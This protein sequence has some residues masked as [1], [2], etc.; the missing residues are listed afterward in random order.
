[1]VGTVRIKDQYRE[2]R[3]F[4]QRALVAGAV[5]GAMVL[6]LLGRLV[7]LQ[8]IHHE[9]YLLRAEG[10]RA[11]IEPIPA[12][13][14]LILDRNGLVLAENQATY[15]LELV[16]EQ[17][18]DLDQTLQGLA[19]IG[20]IAAED[21]E[22]V[23]RDVRAR[24]AFEA[25]P[26]QRRLTEE[27]IAAFAAH[28]HQFPGVD[29]RWR[30][31]RYYP[32]GSLAVHALGY[33]GTISEADLAKIDETAYR[34]TTVIGKRGVEAARE[35]DLHGVNG[36]REILVNAQ[37]RSVQEQGGLNLTLR[38][39]PPRAGSD[40]ILSLD[41]PTQQ[42]A[43]AAFAGRRGAAI[44]L[45][46]HNGDV[47]AFVSLPGFDPSL[48]G[49]GITAKEYRALE[50]DIDRPLFNRA[51][52]GT[53][54]PGS[55][56]KPVLGM[57][58][59]AYG[60]VTPDERRY[61]PGV[62]IVP[63]SSR[64]ARE[65][66][67][68][69]HGAVDLRTS[70]S[71]SCDVYYYSLAVE[72]GVDRIHEFLS[73]FGFG[74]RTGIDIAG[75]VSG[76]LPSREWKKQRYAG[77]DPSEGNWYPGDSVNFGI[78]QGY[79]TVTPMQLAQV[80]AVLAAKG[81]VFQPRLVTGIRDPVSGETRAVEPVELPHVKGGTPAQWDV[82]MEGMRETMISG[83]ARAIATSA[84]Y[85]MAGKTGTAQVFTVAQNQSVSQEVQNERLR[86]HSWFIAFAP[87][88]DP[89]IAVA[90]LVENG[91]FGA[92]AA[93]PIARQ[94][95]DAYLL[96]RLPRAEPAASGAAAAA[97]SR[98]QPPGAPLVPLPQPAD[99]HADH[100]HD[101]EHEHEAGQ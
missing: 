99:A 35:A 7:L 16:R 9:E 83:T 40:L 30:S 15:Q 92:S 21:L 2:Q 80:T 87:A 93:A 6:V 58:G 5:I 48:F 65:G 57:A 88:E 85:R 51:I 67:G 61:C 78:G 13:R 94:M 46:P 63:G 28:R 26:I 66:R 53:Y 14:G 79:M 81:A 55:T 29:I 84:A 59:L 39:R 54:P 22:D 60:V 72:L 23:R 11:R 68:G 3:I 27:Q 64:R 25:V 70:I 18:A 1:M 20:V 97:G 31:A 96:P 75:E 50:G 43:E 91:G 10:N 90:V 12:N 37:G 32:H 52:M 82:I 101:H 86:D 41:L 34:G 76:I 36:F 8:V 77:R 4:F 24:R 33:V 56:V 44:A 17:V 38:S 42:A 100:D 98:Q 74:R 73:P 47:L 45:D 19:A 89:K 62:Y 95:F 49:R 69:V 71:R